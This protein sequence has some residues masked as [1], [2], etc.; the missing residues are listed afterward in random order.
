VTPSD[1][2]LFENIEKNLGGRRFPSDNSLKIALD[3]FSGDLP[4]QSFSEPMQQFEKRQ[5]KCRKVIFFNDPCTFSQLNKLH[6]NLY[7]IKI[8]N[9]RYSVLCKSNTPDKL[10]FRLKTIPNHSF[11]IYHSQDKIYKLYHRN[12]HVSLN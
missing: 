5:N 7:L 12:F 9:P 3:E 10:T 1:F 4:K 8:T 11:Q 6:K 2:F